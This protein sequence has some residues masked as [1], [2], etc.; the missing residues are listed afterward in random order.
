M[1]KF[2]SFVKSIYLNNS[3]YSNNLRHTLR[4]FFEREVKTKHTPTLFGSLFKGSKWVD[5]QTFNINKLFIKS[6]LSYFYY[7]T[8]FVLLLFIFLGRSKSE[9]YFGFLPF[10]SYIN[11]ILGYVPILFSD[12]WS[13]LFFSFYII[14]IYASNTLS[15]LVNY[16]S[17]N[18]FNSLSSNACFENTTKK[19][20]LSKKSPSLSHYLSHK[21]FTSGDNVQNNTPVTFSKTLSKLECKLSLLK[22]SY[23]SYKNQPD[24]TLYNSTL[25]TKTSDK[26][27]GYKPNYTSTE[28][29]YVHGTFPN[30][31]TKTNNSNK[32]LRL[33]LHSLYK[34]YG[35][36]SYP[37]FFDFNVEKNL[38]NAKQQRWLV[39]NSLLSESI[40]NNSFLITQAKKI[41]GLGSLSKDF[42]N[43]TLWL[44]T[45]ASNLSSLESSLYFN[46][47]SNNL[48]SPNLINTPFLNQ[49][50]INNSN[51]NNLNFFENSRLWV[52]KKYFFTNQQAS[53]TIV[54]YPSILTNLD[55]SNTQNNYGN[56]N[57][58]VSLSSSSTNSLITNTLTPSLFSKNLIKN[59]STYST[60]TTNT[61]LNLNNLDVISGSNTSFL[62][63]ITSNPQDSPNSQNYFSNL[64]V[65]TSLSSPDN[66]KYNDV[67]FTQNK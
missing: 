18:L 16:F 54:D 33:N 7:I 57:F 23:L 38:N 34:L 24:C 51:F 44:P 11:F 56:L 9:Q 2:Y 30:N 40:I 52:F 67:K 29:S 1:N 27:I 20:L 37:T 14:Y 53:N 63:L 43:K 47:L 32:S 59:T 21:P 55:F 5:Y 58:N 66:F 41:I 17:V 62:F 13:Q 61:N 60:S 4:I 8:F 28:S 22:S 45:K 50:S 10:F 49:K 15:K 46:N 31:P 3:K 48:L 35:N 25:Q 12:L 6:G 19:T 42:T 26:Y 65:N 64:K 39:R 36:S